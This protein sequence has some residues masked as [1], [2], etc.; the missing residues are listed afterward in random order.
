MFRCYI[1]IGSNLEQPVKQVTQALEELQ[2]LPNTQVVTASRL[3]RSDPLGPVDQPRY[4]NAVAAIDT[5]LKPE[6][7][8]DQLQAIEAIHDRKRSVHWGPRTLDLDLLLYADQ[9]IKT[10]RLT[11]PHIEIGNRAFVLY[12]LAEIAP[13][14]KFPNGRLISDYTKQCTLGTIE[15]I[16]I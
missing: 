3:Y 15:P 6:A 16:D 8:L 1:G 14:L 4:I 5:L 12:P 2:S 10:D 9:V 13:S 11:V 7:L